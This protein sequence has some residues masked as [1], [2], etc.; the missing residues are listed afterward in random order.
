MDYTLVIAFFF[1]AAGSRFSVM[2]VSVIIS[3]MRSSVQGFLRYVWLA[4]LFGCSCGKFL[5]CLIVFV[6]LRH[7]FFTSVCF[8]LGVYSVAELAL[9][10]CVVHWWT[11]VA[12]LAN[13]TLL[14]IVADSF[15]CC[16][17]VLTA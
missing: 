5:S 3:F 7:F 15:T 12:C 10:A 16:L 14:A 13:Y 4:S 17:A 9:L 6:G 8:V 2:S 11:S 1:C